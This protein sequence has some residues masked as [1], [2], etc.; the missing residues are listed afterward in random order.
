MRGLNIIR[1]I[2]ISIW[3]SAAK[4]QPNSSHIPIQILQLHTE[5]VLAP[6]PI[7]IG[8][9]KNPTNA[10]TNCKLSA[11]SNQKLQRSNHTW[12]ISVQAKPQV[13]Q[14]LCAVDPYP[15][16]TRSNSTNRCQFI[17][18]KVHQAQHPLTGIKPCFSNMHMFQIDVM[19]HTNLKSKSFEVIPR[20]CAIG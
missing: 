3:A 11:D 1:S 15:T 2:S 17:S 20:I 14:T 8:Q 16:Y 9:G 10:R 18:N 4:P 5:S 12:P 7:R 6:S 19:K 13:W